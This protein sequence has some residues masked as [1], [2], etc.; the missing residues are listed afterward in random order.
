MK[1]NIH[2]SFRLSSIFVLTAA[3]LS[4]FISV[5][6]AQGA[7]AAKS[8]FAAAA[9]PP[10]QFAAS[11]PDV[12]FDSEHPAQFDLPPLPARAGLKPVLRLRLVVQTS[13]SAGTKAGFGYNSS[14]VFNGVTLQRLTP[15]KQERLLMR[16]VD[17]KLL[18]N[19]QR[20]GIFQ[21]EWLA[22]MFR[23]EI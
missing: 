22:T 16:P 20:Y 12:R 23:R 19:G 8:T 9:N 2:T 10:L 1:L 5:A 15:R 21:E 7:G 13:L 6:N 11:V 14:I 17:L 3:A 18:S 4:I